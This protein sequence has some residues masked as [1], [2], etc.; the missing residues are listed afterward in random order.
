LLTVGS[1]LAGISWAYEDGETRWLA[2]GRG[3]SP[4]VPAKKNRKEPGDYA[5]ERDKG[6]DVV[7]RMFLRLQGLGG[8]KTNMS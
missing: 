4:V 3:Y 6:R 7:E 5:Q 8:G 2:F 1:G